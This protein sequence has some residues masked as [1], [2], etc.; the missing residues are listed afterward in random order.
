LGRISGGKKREMLLRPLIP[1][2]FSLIGGILFGHAVIPHDLH[3]FIWFSILFI[4]LL[5]FSLL[6]PSSYR[7]ISFLLLFF[8]AGIQMDLDNHY[9]SELMNLA[10]ER[11]H[12]LLEATV[13][14]PPAIIE[15]MARFVVRVDRLTCQKKKIQ[16]GEKIL[17]T[18]YGY[19]REFSV[20]EKL[21]FH[22][23]LRPFL[24][25][26]NPGS[27][28][29]RL[30]MVVRSLSCAA[31]VSDGRRIVR[32]GKGHLSFALEKL[33]RMRSPVRR[34]FAENLSPQNKA[35][36]GS[37]VLGERQSITRE[38]REVF[39]ISGLSHVL[40]VSGLHIAVVAWLC[41]TLLKKLLSFSS[42]LILR[43]DIRR[44]S[45]LITCLPVIAY[46][47]LTGF[48]VSAE[49]AMI[50]GLAFLFSLVIGREREIWSTMALAA[51]LVLALDPHGIFSVSAQLSFL[52]VTGILWLAPGI[53]AKLAL[54]TE[55]QVLKSKALNRLYL[56]VAGLVAATVSATVFLLP[57]AT[58]YFHRVP[59]IAI[60]A[61][62]A[63]LPVLGLLVLC[64]GLSASIILFMSSAA[65]RFLLQIG[66]WI[67]DRVMETLQFWTRFDWAAFW[68]VTP[69]FFEILLFYALL[70]FLFHSRRFAWAKIGLVALLCLTG[71]DAAY[72]FDR[73]YY[74]PNLRLTY[75]DVGQGNAA[76]VEFP[77]RDRM[78]ID[79][80]GS[81]GDDFDVGEMVVAPFLF[82]SRLRRVDYIVLTHPDTDHMEGLRFI[83][84][85]FGPKEFWYN[86]EKPDVPGFHELM[87]IVKEK[88][89]KVLTPRDLKEGRDI[90][91]VH[92]TVIHP[93]G[94]E[95]AERFWGKALKS[96][97][98]SLVLR[99]SDKGRSFLF[100]GDLESTG[101]EILL[102][103]E[104]ERLKSDVLLAPHHGSRGSCTTAFLENVAPRICVISSGSGNPFGFPHPETLMRLQRAGCKIM[105]TDQLGAIEVT[106]GPEGLQVR[107]FLH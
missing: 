93:P 66:A 88:G 62:L 36:F 91:G 11:P 63:L 60:P 85:H 58:F 64:L 86:G 81:P 80:G 69:R 76:L 47:A 70:F 53:Y 25:F 30:S 37:L 54:S 105:R 101:E 59:I 39:S 77:G 90:G 13:L 10:E 12:V 48:Q 50:M 24:N 38:L 98:R 4:L 87:R 73:S 57:V 3:P 1:V 26:N 14:E 6:I 89:I 20:G 84:S 18:V 23:R 74:N 78:L 31:S 34:F 16:G 68:G 35:I 28:D 51:L 94:V 61:N 27:Y 65:S 95:N 42:T 82:Y 22:A 8:L 99:I 19:P 103:P 29:Y 106:A 33:E 41:Y 43:T 83:A 49:R 104:G 17:V 40:A 21:F 44:V 15:D 79:G 97:D 55:E 100:P 96:N 9:R 32:M 107:S 2:L 92:I 45:A 72:W 102:L 56:Y 67:L 71:L 46:T 52:A 7:F 75:L 5:I